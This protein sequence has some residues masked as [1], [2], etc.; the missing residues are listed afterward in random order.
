MLSLFLLPAVVTLV[1]LLHF[2]YEYFRDRKGLRRIPNATPISG[3][4]NLW[5]VY[6]AWKGDR[7][8]VLRQK[9]GVA[10]DTKKPV[11]R[12]APNQLSFI[13]AQAIRDIYGHGTVMEKGW[14][15]DLIAG[16][17]RHLADVVDRD[18]H[19]RK[20]KVLSAAFTQAS[21]E[22]HVDKLNAK[23]AEFMAQMDARCVKKAE[24]HESEEAS[25]QASVVDYRRWAVLFTQDFI[26]ALGFSADLGFLKSGDDLTVAETPTGECYK[27]HYRDA[28][29]GSMYRDKVL[30]A[31]PEWYKFLLG[32]ARTMLPRYRM[33]QKKAS[34]FED[35]CRHVVNERLRREAQGDKLHDFCHSI[36]YSRSG[37]PNNYPPGEILAEAHV[38]LN[39][40]SDSTGIAMT[41]T[42]YSLLLNP[43]SLKTLR[44]ELDAVLDADEVVAPYHKIK[45][46]PYVRAVLDE[47]M[48]MNAPSQFSMPRK[49]PPQG[50][51]IAGHYIQGDVGVSV[52]THSIHM[53]PEIWGDP[54]TFRPERWLDESR[55]KQLASIFLVFTT[56]PRGCI[57]KNV[58]YFEQTVMLASFVHRYDFCLAE[59]GFVPTR[60]ETTVTL[61][62]RLPLRL[63]RRTR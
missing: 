1:F 22:G 5:F 48:R 38:I 2:P 28:I 34:S 31:F 61:I 12:I 50:A 24:S 62:D 10:R 55:N 52:P 26:A 15:Y 45:D 41:N 59:P 9:H 8:E 37:E 33:Y 25:A 47:S 16:P 51:S 63:S 44:E 27:V 32:W 42:I 21:V 11:L 43:K 7:Y 17:Y 23:M 39:A 53:D 20:R 60:H 57:G 6:H 56:G 49:T 58:T 19:R 35:I 13:G 29:E 14:H 46:L 40:G 30:I 4:T 3:L 36:L 54:D 18:D